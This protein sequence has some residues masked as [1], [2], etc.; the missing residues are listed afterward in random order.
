[1]ESIKIPLQNLQ[2]STNAQDRMYFLLIFTFSSCFLNRLPSWANI[3]SLRYGIKV[4]GLSIIKERL[5]EVSEEC[6]DLSE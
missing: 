5:V 6:F 3:P 1:M 2:I 4:K